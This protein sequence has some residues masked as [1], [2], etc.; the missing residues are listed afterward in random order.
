MTAY[1]VSVTVLLGWWLAA[2]AGAAAPPTEPQFT[3]SLG[4]EFVRIEPGAFTMGTD[5]EPLPDEIAGKSWRPAGHFDEHPRHAVTITRPFYMAACEVTNEQFEAF[6]P[7]HRALRG[8]LGFSTEDD[9]AVVF[10]S[11]LEATAFCEWLSEKEGLPYRLPTEAEWEYACRAGTATPFS[12]G[13]APPPECMKNQQLS[14]FP[15][16]ERES[17]AGPPRL[18]VGQCPAN[19][20]GLHDM[21]GNVEE[22]CRDWYGPYE[23]GEQA[24]PAGRA[25]G[26]FRVTRGGSHSTEVFYLRSAARMGTVPEDRSWLIGFR[27]VLGEPPATAPLPPAPPERW[28]IDVQ[29]D[30]PAPAPAHEGPYFKGPRTYVKIPAD[31]SGPMYA[32]HNH[33]PGI[34]ACPNGDLLAIWYSCWEEPGREL[35]LL[36]SRLRR[37]NEEWDP[38]APFWDAPG[39]NDHAPALWFD[40]DRT[41]FQFVGLSAAATW[42]NLATVLRTSTDN[43]ATWS[44][45]RLINPEH[46]LRH[47]PVESVFRTAEGAIVLPCDA[48]TTGNGGT[49]IHVSEDHGATWHDPGG[50]IAGIHAGVVQLRDGRLM[51]LGRGDTI[52]GRM[53]VSI[54]ED[55]GKTWTSRAS[56]FPPIGGGQRLAFTRLREGPLFLASFAAE[57]EFTDAD[58][59]ARVGSGLFAALSYDDGETWP[60]RRLITDDGPGREVE[61]MDGRP[62]LMDGDHAEPKGYLSV[63]QAADGVI[64]LIG[65]RN[66]YAFNSAWIEAPPPPR[67]LDNGV[68]AHRGDSDHCPENTLPA[69]QAALDAGADWIELDVVRTKDGELAVLH[70]ATTERVG[71]RALPA[72][73]ATYAELSAVDVAAAFRAAKGLGLDACPKASVPRLRDVLRLIKTQH[74]TRVSIQPKDEVVDECIALIRELD[75]A[76]WCGFNDGSLRKMK[77]VKELDPDI[78]VFWDQPASFDLDNAIETGRA[79]GFEAV[80]VHYSGLDQ[81]VVD[82]LHEAGFEVGAWTVNDPAQM[83][84]LLAMGV[85]RM[86]TDRPATLLR[87]KEAAER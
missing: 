52:D 50:T 75:A 10:V 73:E 45:A 11:W 68:T 49:A 34:A 59:E 6:A 70:D 62:F 64:H 87:L 17:E 78:P 60:V 83:E 44:R 2:S 36:A 58:G 7:G 43:G 23:A 19:P 41:L 84:A 30:I 9:E 21:H 22:W 54:S 8:K 86:Y 65:S 15:D 69:F 74:R 24:D 81:A 71:D 51:A 4:M 61:S 56:A 40:G 48:V 76:A 77:R 37:G 80:V 67:F 25:E 26:D 31:A 47:M 28:Q 32:H 53:P 29:Q 55:M 72:G 13:A 5:A 46:G 42:G 33:D 27:V 82:R 39:R 63:C 38:A 66:H 16:P 20:W 3:N 12:T 79:C 35:C 57:V 14:W 1:T 85:D 18:H